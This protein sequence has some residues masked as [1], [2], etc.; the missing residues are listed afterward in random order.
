VTNGIPL[1]CPLFLPVHTVNRV[2][3]LK[4]TYL[5]NVGAP[6]LILNMTTPAGNGNVP[7]IADQGYLSFPRTAKH[8][9]FH[10]RLMHGV[11]SPPL[12]LA[13]LVCVSLPPPHPF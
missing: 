9:I 10:G 6:T 3:T 2:Q 13:V 1:G 7:I 4:V 12:P 8:T 11:R 5:S